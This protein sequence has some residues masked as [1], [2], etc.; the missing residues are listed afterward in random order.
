MEETTGG[1]RGLGKWSLWSAFIP[2]THEE[3]EPQRLLTAERQKLKERGTRRHGL[4]DKTG[5]ETGDWE[6]V[7]SGERHL[8]LLFWEA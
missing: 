4:L 7:C 1:S 6:R 3:R 8:G 5:S 2:F